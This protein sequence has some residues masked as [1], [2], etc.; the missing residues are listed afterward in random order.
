MANLLFSGSVNPGATQNVDS[1]D[2]TGERT[3]RVVWK[4]AGTV[5]TSDLAVGVRAYDDAGV[6]LDLALTPADNANPQVANGAVWAAQT[7]NIRSVKKLQM[8]AVNNN[9]GALTLS[10]WF[11]FE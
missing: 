10:V 1:P 7:I 11:F 8:R 3:V 5:T 9:V 4:L 2:L 6:L